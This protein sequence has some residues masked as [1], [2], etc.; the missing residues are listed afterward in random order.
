MVIEPSVSGITSPPVPAF[1]QPK[2]NVRP[3]AENGVFITVLNRKA[4]HRDSL[5]QQFPDTWR[6]PTARNEFCSQKFAMPST[7]Q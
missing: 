5:E 6:H 1:A 3:T 4:K 7:Q 2:S